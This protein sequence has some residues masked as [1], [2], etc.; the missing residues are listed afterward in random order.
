MTKK[1]AIIL[2]LLLAVALPSAA[3][4]VA[5]TIYIPAVIDSTLQGKDII[6]IIQSSKGVGKSTINQSS[7]IKTAFQKHVERNS[8]KSMSG[9]RIRVFYDNDR[10]ARAKSEG[11]AHYIA[12]HYPGLRVYRTFESPNFKVTVGD[13]RTKDEALRLFS[14]LK[15][16]YPSAFIIKENINYPLVDAD[17]IFD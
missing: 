3:Q 2:T 5:D 16:L 7:A 17:A 8:S 11:I 13:F 10:T 6:M 15:I 4:D 14:E 12:G 1:L 9:Y